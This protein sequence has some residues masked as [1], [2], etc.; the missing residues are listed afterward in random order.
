MKRGTTAVFCAGFLQG[1][2]FVLIPALGTTLRSAPYDMSNA[3]YGLLYFPEIIGAVF[4]AIS[5]GAIHKRLGSA[6]LFRLGALTNAV[7]MA[8]LVAAFF[9]SG[10]P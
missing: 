8:L 2:A 10:L 4:A 1:A 5:A 7:A 3:T 6:G 9:T